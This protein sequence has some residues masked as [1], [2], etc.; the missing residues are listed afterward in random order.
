MSVF[1]GG[2]ISSVCV[3]VK[4]ACTFPVGANTVFLSPAIS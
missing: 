2:S 1:A 3:Y 4:H